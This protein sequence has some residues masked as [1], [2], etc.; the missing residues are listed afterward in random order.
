MSNQA[1]KNFANNPE[2]KRN[3]CM[4]ITFSS[5]LMLIPKL[6]PLGFKF[7]R[8]GKTSVPGRISQDVLI[9]EVPKPVRFYGQ[10]R[11]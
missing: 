6:M 10:P 3:V 8:T 4:V 1:L 5:G 11:P 9:Q 7:F 2:E